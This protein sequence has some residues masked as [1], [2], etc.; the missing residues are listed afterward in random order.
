MHRKDSIQEND[1]VSE[2]HSTP[3]NVWFF[4]EGG[5]D[6]TLAHRGNPYGPLL[7]IAMA[8]R[9]ITYRHGNYDFTKEWLES[10]RE[11]S[12]I[13]H[14]NWAHLFYKADD[15]ESGVRKLKR[16][17]NN[18]QF[19]KSLG[20]RII[21]TFHNV[22]PHERAFPEIDHDAQ[23]MLCQV[24]DEMIAHCQYAADRCA[25][26]FYR[27]SRLT[28]VPHG[29]YID[30]YPNEVSRAEARSRMGIEPD[31][32]VFVFSG[33][34]RPYKGIDRLIE[35]FRQIAEPNDHLLL[36][37]RHFRFNPQYAL[38]YVAMAGE[39]QN[40]TA[41][42]ADFFERDE[43]QNYLKAADVADLPFVDVLTSGS[44]ILALSFGLPV[45]LPKL[46]CLPELVPGEEGILFD[47]TDPNGLRHAME[48]VRS[49]DLG[50]VSTNAMKRARE[51]DWAT[52]AGTISELYASDSREG[53]DQSHPSALRDF[54]EAREQ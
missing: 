24:A 14:L 28:V 25:E 21:W 52:I 29:N 20:Y 16:F 33:T 4:W 17:T 35:T 39:T 13:L 43:F 40:I 5:D 54:P 1:K 7:A 50:A 19:A 42:S 15:L 9:G 38:D 2:M 47:P 51:L 31:A 8:E 45:I 30:A 53:L 41:V 22:Y 11:S 32:R 6:F 23:V 37:M 12:E 27:Q 26:L 49:M 34:A 46:G 10:A 36:M 18:L 3:T 48:S 44:A